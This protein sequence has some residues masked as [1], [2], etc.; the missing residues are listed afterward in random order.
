MTNS[1]SHPFSSPSSR[2]RRIPA[3][4]SLSS[5]SIRSYGPDQTTRR[6]S[7]AG[8]RSV[9]TFN[10]FRANGFSR[11]LWESDS[12]HSS[13]DNLRSLIELGSSRNGQRRRDSGGGQSHVVGGGGRRGMGVRFPKSRDISGG[14]GE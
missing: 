4:E 7:Q 10:E 9:D 6:Y 13:Q 8:S 3:N 11:S 2:A 14:I 12:S 1:R 5:Y